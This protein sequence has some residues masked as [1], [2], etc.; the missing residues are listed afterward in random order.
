[1]KGERV[2]ELR[3]KIGITQTDLA[4]KIGESKQTLYKY[5]NNII[6]NVPSDKVELMAKELGCSPAYLMGW[7]DTPNIPAPEDTVRSM[8][9]RELYNHFSDEKLDDPEFVKQV[10][11][12][13]DFLDK[14]DPDGR[15]ALLGFARTLK[16]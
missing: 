13:I 12:F 11:S 14:L 1:M 5:E 4:I 6:T 10:M 3:E 2:K 7:I 16:L 8:L 9:I 15:T